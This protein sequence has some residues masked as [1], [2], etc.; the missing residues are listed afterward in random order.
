M[1]RELKETFRKGFDND[2]FLPFM[3]SFIGFLV[4]GSDISKYGF[5]EE[6]KAE[7]I[8]LLQ[9]ILTKSKLIKNEEIFSSEVSKFINLEEINSTDAV[10]KYGSDIEGMIIHTINTFSNILLLN[11]RLKNFEID[12]IGIVN[13]RLENDFLV[14]LNSTLMNLISF[15]KRYD[16]ELF[17]S[18]MSERLSHFYEIVII[19]DLIHRILNDNSSIELNMNYEKYINMEKH[20]EELFIRSNY[21]REEFFKNDFKPYNLFTNI[22]D[23]LE[24]NFTERL[25]FALDKIDGIYDEISSLRNNPLN[26]IKLFNALVNPF[27][28]LTP[29]IFKF[30]DND[31]DIVEKKVK[32][33][34]NGFLVIILPYEFYSSLRMIDIDLKNYINFGDNPFSDFNSK[35]NKKIN[36]SNLDFKET[37]NSKIN[38]DILDIKHLSKSVLNNIYDIYYEY[39]YGDSDVFSRF[40]SGYSNINEIFID[41]LKNI[42]SEKSE[43]LEKIF[44]ELI[45][46][47]NL[48]YLNLNYKPNIINNISDLEINLDESYIDIDVKTSIIKLIPNI[49]NYNFDLNKKYNFKSLT[50]NLF[51]DIYYDIINGNKFDSKLRYILKISLVRCIL[52]KNKINAIGKASL[53]KINTNN[54]SI[55]LNRNLFALSNIDNLAVNDSLSTKEIFKSELLLNYSFIHLDYDFITKCDLIIES[56]S[57]ALV[58]DYDAI[59]NPELFSS[60]NLVIKDILKDDNIKT[61]PFY[62]FKSEVDENIDLNLNIDNFELTYLSFTDKNFYKS[63][64]DLKRDLLKDTFKDLWKNKNSNS[65]IKLENFIEDNFGKIIFKKIIYKFVNS[66]KNLEINFSS[67]VNI[68]NWCNI[69]SKT[70]NRNLRN[71]ILNMVSNNSEMLVN[72]IDFTFLKFHE[73]KSDTSKIDDRVGN[74]NYKL[75]GPLEIRETFVNKIDKLDYINTVYL[76]EF[77]NE[78]Y[79]L[80]LKD[81]KDGSIIKVFNND[82]SIKLIIK[83]LINKLK[84][85]S[86]LEEIT[87][88]IDFKK[89]GGSMMTNFTN[90]SNH[91]DSTKKI[92]NENHL[93]VNKDINIVKFLNGGFNS[94]DVIYNIL[95]K[96]T[97]SENIVSELKPVQSNISEVIDYLDKLSKVSL[98]VSSNLENDISK[99]NILKENMFILDSF[100][101]NLISETLDK[102]FSK[103]AYKSY[104]LPLPLITKIIIV[105]LKLIKTYTNKEFINSDLVLTIIEEVFLSKRAR[106][107][108]YNVQFTYG[109]NITN[110]SLSDIEN[111]IIMGMSNFIRYTSDLRKIHS[112]ETINNEAKGFFMIL[113]FYDRIS[114][115]IINKHI[116]SLNYEHFISFISMSSIV[117]DLH[118][119]YFETVDDTEEEFDLFIR[120]VVDTL[121]ND[122][123]FEKELLKYGLNINK[124]KELSSFKFYDEFKKYNIAEDEFSIEV[125]DPKNIITSFKLGEITSCCQRLGSAAETCVVDGVMNPYSFFIV[126]KKCNKIVAQSYSFITIDNSTIV[127]DNIECNKDKLSKVDS[128]KLTNL[129]IKYLSQ[130][131]DYDI[132]IGTSYTDLI[133][134]NEYNKKFKILD[135]SEIVNN[136]FKYYNKNAKNYTEED[137]N[138]LYEKFRSKNI[139]ISIL[140]SIIFKLNELEELKENIKNYEEKVESKDEKDEMFNELLKE[141]IKNESKISDKDYLDNYLSKNSILDSIESI[142]DEEKG[143]EILKENIS[144]WNISLVNALY[145]DAKRRFELIK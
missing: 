59:E 64:N 69:F 65:L 51:E 58:L 17:K 63:F 86:T 42:L 130:F 101:T 138:S 139:D 32:K 136:Y 16:Y 140:D 127:L 5:K 118:D 71:I 87:N 77:F 102:Y 31:M 99:N 83:E 33:S 116:D 60:N 62:R 15:N 11:R 133:E 113:K 141:L 19:D 131:K 20:G 142:L 117:T 81:I 145:S 111:I 82:I 2:N 120:K 75:F 21:I 56:F 106:H 50:L 137:I 135:S 85:G 122:T 107:E 132:H 45:D 90:D 52:D 41:G 143:T 18:E 3:N 43:D 108:I 8:E 128:S 88:Y 114:F 74:F 23:D 68:V 79:V 76:H 123:K 126:A 37:R 30:E 55:C 97:N 46:K 24:D 105:S 67:I 91:L 100:Y 54:D 70:K 40:R 121:D 53:N 93:F 27:L 4:N 104:A 144:K 110:L 98:I 35:L 115:K 13:C 34:L 12:A 112:Y 89:I 95:T 73:K 57:N 44:K 129:Y 47:N 134:I 38:K 9:N 28:L 103:Y 29:S 109:F 26:G 94:Y 84:N 7:L 92:K 124:V 72:N 125:L 96:I 61:L 119:L 25:F 49:C 66:R 22:I 78:S 14:P 10:I 1:K 36:I 6:D 48:L 39:F 80:N